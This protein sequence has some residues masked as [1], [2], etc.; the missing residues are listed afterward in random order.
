MY[1]LS[2]SYQFSVSIGYR[3]FVL[4][5]LPV[6]DR[7]GKLNPQWI[8][9]ICADFSVKE[10]LKTF[11]KERFGGWDSVNKFWYIPLKFSQIN[12]DSNA[13]AEVIWRNLKEIIDLFGESLKIGGNVNLTIESLSDNN[14]AILEEKIQEAIAVENERIKLKKQWD[15]L[16]QI[17]NKVWVS[18]I[19]EENSHEYMGF[20][21][22]YEADCW[23]NNG[24]AQR[25][26]VMGEVEPK[27]FAEHNKECEEFGGGKYR[28]YKDEEGKLQWCKPVKRDKYD[29]GFWEDYAFPSKKTRIREI[30]IDE[31][32][33]EPKKEPKVEIVQPDVKIAVAINKEREPLYFL[34][35]LHSDLAFRSFLARIK[36][37]EGREW[38][39]KRKMWKVP[40]DHA[41]NLIK[42]QG[43]YQK[44][45]GI[46]SN[47]KFEVSSGASQIFSETN[48]NYK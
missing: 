31:I 28:Q 45:D 14:R 41:E 3:G 23:L 6:K 4:D 33:N 21:G 42:L 19:D 13:C 40:L 32:V 43:D 35:S 44:P 29:L 37:L 16:P 48:I 25:V 18:D 10:E 15:N 46:V 5:R 11:C 39:G 24:K 27:D 20:E 8:L 38:D 2:F 1:S 30:A 7:T 22:H 47:L 9:G 26:I 17:F 34:V 36:S 12:K